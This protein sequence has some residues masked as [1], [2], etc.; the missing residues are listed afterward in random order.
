MNPSRRAFL[1]TPAALFAQP[2]GG[3][4]Y[5]I[6][7]ETFAGVKIDEACR[8]ARRTGYEGIEIEP[9]Q[10][11]ADPAALT[12]GERA[13]I[14]NAIGGSGVR[15]TGL[16]SLLRAPAGLHLTTPDPSVRGKSWEYFRRLIDLAADLGD[17]AVMVLGS[18]RQRMAVDGTTPADAVKRLTEGLASVAGAARARGVTILV[19]PLA[20]HLCNVV[21]TLAEAMEI[22]R[23]VASP[24]VETMFDTHNTA[25]EKEPPAALIRKYLPH[26][27][28]VHLNEMD[29]RRPGAGDYPFLEVLRALREVR[30]R[31][32]V[33]VEVFDFKP[34]GETVARQAREFLRDLE[35]RLG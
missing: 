31:H 21:N 5:A 23:A 9:A 17:E 8:A 35:R 20:P 34:D 4:R 28:H 26:I 13:S 24:A 33:S 32:W 27:R 18:S 29:G 10:L 3:L 7:S 15:Y 19:E 1:F 30:F 16:H 12:A 14:R 2:G 25:A 22:V 11:S 6:C